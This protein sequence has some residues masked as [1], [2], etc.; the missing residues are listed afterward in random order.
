MSS[1]LAWPEQDTSW[2]LLLLGRLRSRLWR[3]ARAITWP[4]W[5]ST[6]VSTANSHICSCFSPERVV[7]YCERLNG[8]LRQ[9][10]V[11][12]TELGPPIS[13]QALDSMTTWGVSC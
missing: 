4:T 6:Q 7:L 2:A 11:T 12:Q 9:R 8:A 1:M 5:C 13:N 10:T 3:V